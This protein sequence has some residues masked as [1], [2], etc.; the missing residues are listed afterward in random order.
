[1]DAGQAEKTFD[2]LDGFSIKS[3]SDLKRKAVVQNDSP[4]SDQSIDV[5]SLLNQNEEEDRSEVMTIRLT[6]SA[7]KKIEQIWLAQRKKRRKVKEST[8]ASEILMKVLE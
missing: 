7:R 6:P 3:K 8:I 5:M 1:M 2:E 4:D